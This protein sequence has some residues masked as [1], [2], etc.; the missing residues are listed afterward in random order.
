MKMLVTSLTHVL[1][2]QEAGMHG[3]E[4]SFQVVFVWVVTS[5]LDS[6]PLDTVKKLASRVDLLILSSLLES[7]HIGIDRH[8]DGR[9]L[10]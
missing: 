6:C 3:E 1:D 9:T 10:L 2:R 4:Q 8:G 5:V 7:R